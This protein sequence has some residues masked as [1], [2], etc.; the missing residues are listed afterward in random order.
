VKRKY[1]GEPGITVG[2]VVD[3]TRFA[4]QVLYDGKVS[5]VCITDRSLYIQIHEARYPQDQ[6]PVWF[7]HFRLQQQQLEQQ[8]QQ[9]QQLEQQR[10]NQRHNELLSLISNANAISFNRAAN[11]LLQPLRNRHGAI[12]DSF[13]LNKP[14]LFRLSNLQI[15]LLLGA[16]EL[17]VEGSLNEK[18]NRLAIHIGLIV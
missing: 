15:N 4:V 16:Y 11:S 14:D 13:P 9:Q 17:Q 18:R 3:A 10:N 12:P 8:R 1:D 2:H 6:E 5:F 7:Q